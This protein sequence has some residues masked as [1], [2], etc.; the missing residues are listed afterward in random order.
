MNRK[1][2]VKA[3]NGKTVYCILDG[4][5]PFDKQLSQFLGASGGIDVACDENEIRVRLLLVRMFNTT[6]VGIDV[7]G[8]PQQTNFGRDIVFSADFCYNDI[9]DKNG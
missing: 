7:L 5:K 3:P 4:G 6:F 1:I 8:D 9:G 2:T